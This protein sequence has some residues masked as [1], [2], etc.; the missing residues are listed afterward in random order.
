MNCCTKEVFL[1]PAE[2]LESCKGET[3]F[4]VNNQWLKSDDV[5]MHKI[6]A[7]FGYSKEHDLGFDDSKWALET[8]ANKKAKGL[9]RFS[10]YFSKR[11][12]WDN[13]LKCRIENPNKLIRAY[14]KAGVDVQWLRLINKAINFKNQDEFSDFF[15]FY[16]SEKDRP[17]AE[18]YC[19]FLTWLF[20]EEK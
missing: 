7:L 5:P 18:L 13:Y 4:K 11:E 14:R 12:L 19:N 10:P 3:W 1:L 17:V 15:I 20:N 16:L 8:W 2:L 6:T 9:E